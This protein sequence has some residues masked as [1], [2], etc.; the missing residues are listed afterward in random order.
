MLSKVEWT[1]LLVGNQYL[2][3]SGN[4]YS[5]GPLLVTVKKVWNY[6]PGVAMVYTDHPTL[7]FQVS[8]VEGP[9]DPKNR[10]Y[11]VPDDSYPEKAP[12]D[13]GDGGI[14]AM[15]LVLENVRHEEVEEEE[16]PN[17]GNIEGVY[18]G[19]ENLN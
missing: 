11:I 4:P 16:N 1:D 17:F 6:M 10:F 5:P 7:V 9:I 18:P 15:R 2:H 13:L 3:Y 8:T 12:E 19:E 14:S